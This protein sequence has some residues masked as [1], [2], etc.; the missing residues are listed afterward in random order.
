[1]LEIPTKI[2]WRKQYTRSLHWVVPE[3]N[4]T[5][6]GVWIWI[7]GYGIS[8]GIKEIACGISRGDQEKIMWN[9]QG[10]WF[11]VLEFPRDGMHFFTISRGKLNKRKILGGLSNQ[12]VVKFPVCFF[13]GIAHCIWS[14]I[15]TF[16]IICKIQP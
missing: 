6:G 2:R 11:L 15:G 9:F 8:R 16:I 7:W 1:M 3:K 13:S 4:Q 14:F 10:S 5:G 12:Y